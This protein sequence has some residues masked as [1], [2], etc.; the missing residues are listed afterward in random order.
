M[1]TVHVPVKLFNQGLGETLS[2]E[3]LEELCFEFGME[4]EL[5]ENE[6][7]EPNKYAFETPSNRNDLLCTE[8]IIRNLAVFLGRA[9][10][11][12]FT[13]LNPK[14]LEKMV[15]KKDVKSQLFSHFK[16]GIYRLL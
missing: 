11:P 6:P 9:A 1:P 15:V 3:K 14:T 8:G 5:I 10:V 7:K 13:P 12:N 4:V 16:F 2:L